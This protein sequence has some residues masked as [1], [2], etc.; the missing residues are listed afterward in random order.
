MALRE[1]ELALDTRLADVGPA[2]QRLR[3]LLPDWL[4]ANERDAIELA[5]TEVLS[6]IVRHGY[7]GDAPDKIRVRVLER[8]AAL[9]ID[10]WD[11]GRPIPPGMLEA[12]DATTTFAFDPTDLAALPEGGMGLALI[13]S[14]FHDVRYGSRGGV[15]RLHMVRRL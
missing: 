13:K 6:N 14:A 10:V 5:V 4:G 2:A 8:P 9:E 12:A 15:N 3:D 11:K 1:A 7:G